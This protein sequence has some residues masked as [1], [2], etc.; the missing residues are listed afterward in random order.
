LDTWLVYAVK[1]G[2]CGTFETKG[3]PDMTVFLGIWNVIPNV[4]LSLRG[5]LM[6]RL[7]HLG[8]LLLD[9]LFCFCHCICCSLL[10]ATYVEWSIY[11]IK[12]FH[13]YFTLSVIIFIALNFRFCCCC[14]YCL[15]HFNSV[16]YQ[17]QL[18]YFV[19]LLHFKCP[20]PAELYHLC[21][22]RCSWR[23]FIGTYKLSWTSDNCLVA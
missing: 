20:L 12:K 10:I 19:S 14:H 13:N 7:N 1:A 23:S 21:W 22:F 18:Q 3:L 6:D 8:N 15:L 9:I 11:N 16:G 17:K 4:Y 5:M 2:M